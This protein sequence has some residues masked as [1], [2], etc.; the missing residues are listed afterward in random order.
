M[1]SNVPL[2][3]VVA[4]ALRQRRSATLLLWK[5]MF[6]AIPKRNIFTMSAMKIIVEVSVSICVFAEGIA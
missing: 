4:K 1:E 3:F 5:Y 2:A 6:V